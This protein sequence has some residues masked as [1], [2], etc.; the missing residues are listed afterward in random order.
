MDRDRPRTARAVALAPGREVVRRFD[1]D[2]LMPSGRS[3]AAAVGLLVGGL[4]AFVVARQS[5]VFAIR[6]IEVQGAP[7]ALERQVRAA[8][9]PLVGE[10]LVTL[11]GSAV[12]DR[13]ARLREVRG[14]TYDRSFPST[15]RVLVRPDRPIA[16]VRSG[17]RAWLVSTHG[18]VLRTLTKR[19][20]PRLPR[21]W[22]AREEAPTTTA[23]SVSGLATNAL[24]A[25]ADARRARSSLWPALWTVRA[26]AGELTVVLR[27]R[28]EVRLGDA[29]DVPLKLA[30][31]ARVLR[32]LPAEERLQLRYLD[33]TMPARPVGG[34]N[35]RLSS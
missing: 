29:Y 35:P 6:T 31:A 25:L 13:L 18:A 24:R 34:N 4:A 11:E 30:V 12:Q 23:R 33:V 7:P 8:L 1:L 10:S 27:S 15:L 2:R 9:A 22:V 17:P 3:L 14:A 32:A 19:P 16:V 20:Y 26:K 5:T 21:V 28:M